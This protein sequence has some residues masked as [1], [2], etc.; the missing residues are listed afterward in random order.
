MGARQLVPGLIYR[1][2]AVE[3]VRDG[4]R[5]TTG[6]VRGDLLR[7][8]RGLY[9]KAPRGVI[10]RDQLHHLRVTPSALQSNTLALVIATIYSARVAPYLRAVANS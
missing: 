10:H 9:P 1:P 7:A 2:T 8:G 4:H 3:S 6:V 5:R